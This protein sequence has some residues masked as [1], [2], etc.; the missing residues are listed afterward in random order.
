MQMLKKLTAPNAFEIRAARQAVGLTQGQAADVVHS[1]SYRTWQDWELGKASMPIG[2]WELFLLKTGQMQ[3]HVLAAPDVP[4]RN[5]PRIRK[6][7]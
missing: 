6:C 4:P 2:L 5:K 1:P 3:M 7:A